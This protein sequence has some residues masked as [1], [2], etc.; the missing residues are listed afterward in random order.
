MTLRPC[1]LI[2]RCAHCRVASPQKVQ[3]IRADRNI[4]SGSRQ[5]KFAERSSPGHCVRHRLV[6]MS[7]WGQE[8]REPSRERGRGCPQCSL[9]GHAR[10]NRP[11][12]AKGHEQ[13]SDQQKLRHVGRGFFRRALRDQ[14]AV[15]AFRFRRHQPRRPALAKIRPGRPAPAMGPG[16][17]TPTGVK[18]TGPVTTC[19]AIR[20]LRLLLAPPGHPGVNNERQK[21]PIPTCASKNAC[22]IEPLTTWKLLEYQRGNRFATKN[23]NNREK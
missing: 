18:L 17:A 19:T 2:V 11:T 20:S 15:S 5:L 12:S 16:T 8:R 9:T 21:S 6:G 13:T 7:G 3:L 23:A 22:V 1:R 10:P 4:G 14:A